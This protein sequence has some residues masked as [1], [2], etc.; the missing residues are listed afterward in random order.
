MDTLTLDSF[1]T[2]ERFPMNPI[3]V[4]LGLSAITTKSSLAAVSKSAY[5]GKV[6]HAMHHDTIN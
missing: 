6:G 5:Q 1:T 3:E 2:K 4:P